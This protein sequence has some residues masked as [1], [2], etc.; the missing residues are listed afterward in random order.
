MT[1]GQ[2]SFCVAD[3]YGKRLFDE[4][5]AGRM[6]PE[7][8]F[9]PARFFFRS[10]AALFTAA[11]EV[12]FLGFDQP[13]LKRNPDNYGLY[14]TSRVPVPFF[15]FGIGWSAD[16]PPNTL[17]SWGASLE[18]NGPRV[19]LFEQN[20]GGFADAC[21]NATT[22]ADD[23]SLYRFEH[24]V[25]LA[26]WRSFSWLLAEPDQRLALERFWLGYLDDLVAWDLP[27]KMEAFVAAGKTG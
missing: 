26:R 9:D 23:L 18:V 22:N 24:H 19:A 17:P 5:S 15:W 16:D 11:L 6:V 2:G 20:A 3:P 14:F 25:E 21:E 4:Q 10:N 27:R 1:T 12:R 13:T 8:A 7:R